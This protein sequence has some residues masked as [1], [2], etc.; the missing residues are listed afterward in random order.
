MVMFDEYILAL[1]LSGEY[2]WRPIRY[3]RGRIKCSTQTLRRK[4]LDSCPSQNLY[5]SEKQ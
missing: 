5:L 1:G 4:E 2:F 3:S